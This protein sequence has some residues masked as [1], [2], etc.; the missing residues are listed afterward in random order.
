MNT[1]AICLAITVVAACG[2]NKDEGAAGES[3]SASPT[4]KPS[5]AKP[6]KIDEALATEIAKTQVPGFTSKGGE[7]RKS[8]M[9]AVYSAEE[10]PGVQVVANLGACQLCQKM[11][12]ALW[13][14]NE[15]LKKMLSSKTASDPE[16]VWEIDSVDLGGGKQG[17]YT[18]ALAYE[19]S[20]DGKSRG[21][22]NAYNLWFNDGTNQLWINTSCRGP[23]ADSVRDEAS[24]EATCPR[25]KQL[26]AAKQVFAAFAKY[27]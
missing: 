20:E 16:L 15:N 13:K 25:D 19:Q 23:F 22:V 6:P 26:A 9:Y 5:T 14:K 1:R 7:V 27:F 17:I 2:T 11:D 4:A 24:L 10:E 21:G 8:G 12:L 3:G 18:Y